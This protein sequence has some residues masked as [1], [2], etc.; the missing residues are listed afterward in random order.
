LVKHHGGLQN[1]GHIDEV[2]GGVLRAIDDGD[3][4]APAALFQNRDIHGPLSID[5]YNVGLNRAGI[6]GL[7]DVGHHNGAEADALERNL[8]GV[9]RFRHLAIGINVVVA[10]S[11]AHIASGKNQV[12]VVHRANDIHE[13]ELISL[14]LHGIDI[15][16]DLPVGSAKRLRHRGALHVG[17]LIPHLKLRQIFQLSFVQAFALQ[18]DQANRKAGGVKLQHDRRESPGRKTAKVSHSQVGNVA[19]SRVG[20]GSRLEID[21]D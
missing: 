7:A 6:F 3:G 18:R 11:D 2:L 1:I 16:L 20:I 8:I 10:I 5:A 4:V 21:L 19:E 13:A 15:H 17:N 14:E 12:G 9:R